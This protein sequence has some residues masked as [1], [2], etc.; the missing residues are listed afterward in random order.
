LSYSQSAVSAAGPLAILGSANGINKTSLKPFS[1][2]LA[3]TVPAPAGVF[4]MGIT[5]LQWDDASATHAET[6]QQ[7]WSAGYEHTLSKR[8]ALYTDLTRGRTA[9]LPA[10]MAWDMG[11]KHK[12]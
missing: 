12:F 3:A 1:W 4:K 2:T 6:S 7:K 8:T 10:I 9:S 5:R 11:I